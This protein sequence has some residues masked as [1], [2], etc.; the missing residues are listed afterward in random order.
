MIGPEDSNQI[1]SPAN[2]GDV[3]GHL[4]DD[5]TDE[6]W[7]FVLAFAKV[8]RIPKQQLWEYGSKRLEELMREKEMA[9]KAVGGVRDEVG[10]FG[11]LEREM[12]VDVEDGEETDDDVQENGEVQ[13]RRNKVWLDGSFRL[14]GMLW[15]G[16]SQIFLDEVGF[17]L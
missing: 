7:E 5:K 8:C 12:E 10:G 9:E 4:M 17:D 14:Q 6:A 3:D 13:I 2:A 11:C 16:W 15:T 1:T